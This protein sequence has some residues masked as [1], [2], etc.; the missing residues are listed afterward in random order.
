MKQEMDT[1][2]D[3]LADEMNTP[4]DDALLPE[5]LY[6]ARERAARLARKKRGLERIAQRKRAA[7][8]ARLRRIAEKKERAE[9]R[10]NIRSQIRREIIPLDDEEVR[11]ADPRYVEQLISKEKKFP[12]EDVPFQPFTYVPPMTFSCRYQCCCL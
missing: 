12:E 6:S 9:A 4:M 8:E 2:N 3:Q 1:L 7:E 11:A 10:R 5:N